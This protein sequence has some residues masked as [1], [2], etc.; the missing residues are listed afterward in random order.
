M[1]MVINY[2]LDLF[3]LIILIEY[4]LLK[5]KPR[6]KLVNL[7]VYCQILLII[8]SSLVLLFYYY[9]LIILVSLLSIYRIINL[10]FYFNNQT[11]TNLQ[12]KKPLQSS[13][14]LTLIQ[15]V[16][17]LIQLALNDNLISS[18]ILINCLT[19]VILIVLIFLN[20]KLIKASR[21]LKPP[22]VSVHYYDKDLPTVS[23]LIPARNES[24]SLFRCLESLVSSDYPKL[25]VLV[26]DDCSQNK[27]TAE[28]IKSFAH[29]GVIFIEGQLPPDDWLAKNY[30]YQQLFEQANGDILL[31]CGVDMIFNHHSIRSMIELMLSRK[32]NLISFMPKNYFDK[33]KI[34]SNF[35]YQ[36]IRYNFEIMLSN[37]LNQK[38]GSLTSCWMI[39][40]QTLHKLDGFNQLKRNLLPEKS[41]AKALVDNHLKY[42]FYESGKYVDLT[43]HKTLADQKETAIRLSF[44]KLNQQ[45]SNLVLISLFNI[46]IFILPLG[47]IF[48]S[49]LSGNYLLALMASLSLL[50]AIVYFDL[51]MTITYHHLF[52]FLGI[53]YFKYLYYDLYINHYSMISYL[54]SRVAWKERNICL[55]NKLD[56]Q[57]TYLEL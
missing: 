28:I 34:L 52:R 13:L 30:A 40:S 25:E 51:L 48:I 23:V 2:P 35:N 36:V 42:H 4:G 20:Y 39:D 12:L 43:S 21:K 22:R 33:T 10:Y 44:P 53:F 11:K 16:I 27:K 26:L 45:I 1:V 55:P 5:F 54:T 46:I 57:P 24:D 7:L 47:L 18:Q 15:L 31:F 56:N 41:L 19:L 6:F 50:A 17:I 14:N 49:L 32:D 9:D 38:P 37:L 8:F 3:C 29:H